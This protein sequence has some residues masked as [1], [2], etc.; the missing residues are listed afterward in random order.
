MLIRSVSLFV[1]AVLFI[2]LTSGL[3]QAQ[4]Y[5]VDAC[6]AKY[7]A[8]LQTLNGGAGYSLYLDSGTLAWAESY[9][10]DDFYKLYAVTGDRYWLSLMAEHI[11]QSIYTISQNVEV[12]S[13]VTLT[14]DQLRPVVDDLVHKARATDMTRLDEFGYPTWLSL[15]PGWRSKRYSTAAAKVVESQSAVS[16]LSPDPARI[17]KLDR[18]KEVTGHRYEIHFG[19]EYHYSVSDLT[20]GQFLE[21]WAEFKYGDPITRIPGVTVKV[22]WAP[23]KGDQFIIQTIEQ[24]PLQFAAHDGMM[25]YP[26]AKFIEL[27]MQDPNLRSMYGRKAES[28]MKFFQELYGKKWDRYWVEYSAQSGTYKSTESPAELYPNRLLPVNQNNALARAYLVFSGQGVSNDVQMRER[29][30]RML[31]YFK[32]YLKQN[33]SAWKWNYWEASV[34]DTQFYTEDTSH[35]HTDISTALEGYH[36][37]IVFDR[38]TMMGFVHTFLDVM[39]NGSMDNPNFGDRVD[40]KEGGTVFYPRSWVE[41]CEFSPN[42]WNVW[43]NWFRAKGEP[44]QHIPSLLYGQMLFRKFWKT[45]QK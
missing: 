10:L 29:S 25:L 38:E 13:A 1:I 9:L 39:W 41:L 5:N 22:E 44:V 34:P 26:I 32:N 8:Y 11:D 42:V 21:R 43:A 23:K 24:K 40:S 31:Q 2:V 45:P 27:V 3:L 7:K 33:G 4:E 28:Y 35:A 20:A 36:R 6:V 17:T 14:S 30:R 16:K 18:A 15:Y 19:D 37:G 12:T